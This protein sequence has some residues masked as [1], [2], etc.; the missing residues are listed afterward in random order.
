MIAADVQMAFQRLQSALGLSL[1]C[2]QL[3]LNVNNGEL[4]SIEKI[5]EFERVPSGKVLD[6]QKG[7]RVP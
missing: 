5:R 4:A 6:K 2:G 3:T 1:V 7:Q